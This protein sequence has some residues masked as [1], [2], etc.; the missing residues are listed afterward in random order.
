MAGI[1]GKRSFAPIRICYNHLMMSHTRPT[2]VKFLS[3]V[4]LLCLF[5]CSQEGAVA[6]KAADRFSGR[7][8]RAEARADIQGGRPVRL[9]SQVYNGFAPGYSSPGILDCSPQVSTAPIFL[10]LPEADFHEG[11]GPPSLDDAKRLSSALRFARAY[12]R[13]MFQQR[14]A[15]IKSACPTARLEPESAADSPT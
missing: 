7:D 15:E 2:V 5:A 1:A 4:L 14:A 9:Y 3:G 8:G 11:E 12:N 6:S 13:E 10:S